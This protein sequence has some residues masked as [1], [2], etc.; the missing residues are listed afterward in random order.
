MFVDAHAVDDA[1]RAVVAVVALVRRDPG[2]GR[3]VVHVELGVGADLRVAEVMVVVGAC[4]VGVRAVEVEG[5]DVLGGVPAHR[6]AGGGAFDV[7]AR[8]PAR[9]AHL[10]EQVVVGGLAGRRGVAVVDGVR[11]VHAADRPDVLG[12]A[13]L[14]G[15][16]LGPV[17][18]ERA[19]RGERVQVGHRGR[20]EA[21]THVRP[22][23]VLEREHDHVLVARRRRGGRIRRCRPR[24]RRC[25]RHPR[26]RGRPRRCCR[27]CRR[28]HH[29][30]RR[31]R[32]SR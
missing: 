17:A 31:C 24:G 20:R 13:V 30:R 6:A 26:R 12:Q 7:V 14:L 3:Q 25:R 27:S 16:R 11:V 10:T 23:A 22:G 19:L 21:E 15:V 9:H 5:R 29:R 18:E 8:R 4:R 2:E 32:R 28:S 1:V